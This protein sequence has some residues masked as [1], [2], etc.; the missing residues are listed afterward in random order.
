MKLF[1]MKKKLNHFEKLLKI[2][3]KNLSW[4]KDDIVKKSFLH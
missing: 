3:K 1:M 2:L 4:T